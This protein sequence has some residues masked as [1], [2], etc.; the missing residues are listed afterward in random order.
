MLPELCVLCFIV[1]SLLRL[2]GIWFCF[3][4]YNY[5]FILHNI[6]Y[7]EHIHFL[8][9][10]FNRLNTFLK[11]II[12][13]FGG[14]T[15]LYVILGVFQAAVVFITQPVFNKLPFTSFS[16]SVA[17]LLFA[18]NSIYVIYK[19]FQIVANYNFWTVIELIILSICI[20][21]I[22]WSV[23]VGRKKTTTLLNQP[24]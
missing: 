9:N 13:F 6:D 3:F 11:I 8:L 21:S 18:A 4:I 2:F 22:N 10:W 24:S 15:L 1:I 19:L 14:A 17:F 5:T 12:G 20:I 16:A 7:L 23:L